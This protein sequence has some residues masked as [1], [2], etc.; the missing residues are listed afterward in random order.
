MAG[1]AHNAPPKFLTEPVGISSGFA[2]AAPEQTAQQWAE[3]SRH[4]LTAPGAYEWWY[5]H[6]MSPAGDGVLV[7]LFEGLPFHPR[8]LTQINRYAER[9]GGSI[10]QKKPWASLDP[11]HY[12]AAY[13][14]VYQGGKRVCQFLN[15]YPPRSSA[16]EGGNVQIG[17]NRITLRQDG[18][19]G[20]AVKG[21]PFENVRGRPR[22]RTD[23][24]LTMNLTLAPTFPG[25]QHTSLFRA[26]DRTGA[27]HHWV[28]AAPHGRMTGE[29]QL[30][31]TADVSDPL[32]E[33]DVNALAYHD[34]V[35]GQGGLSTDVSTLIW[36]F[37]Q[38]ED[39][40]AAWHHSLGS[41]ASDHGDG[42]FFFQKDHPPL[43][44]NAPQSRLS[45]HNFSNWLLKHPGEIAMHG[46]DAR[47]H[48]VE[49]L[50][51]HPSVLDTAPFHTRLSAKGTLS[52]PGRGIGFTG[53]GT[54]HVLKLP[55]CAGR[56]SAT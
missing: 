20:V 35:Y 55:A 30:L 54:T 24:I 8:Y 3:E 49:L 39:W 46:S 48:P 31:P 27:T 29:V 2:G 52:L 51:S 10:L 15:L 28:L 38:G 45:R 34:H 47:G 50:L 43:I 41:G 56:C 26:P 36:G 13:A 16:G 42:L 44:I 18:S 19:I 17:P 53:T 7:T 1:T 5:F 33:M 6:A 40:T 23:R 22:K 21:Y 9:L 14:A 32:L 4:R 37:I 11:T 25:V 12:P